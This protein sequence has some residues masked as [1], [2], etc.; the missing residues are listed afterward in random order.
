MRSYHFPPV[1]S[2]IKSLI[3]A[4][5]FIKNPFPILDEAVK[6]LGSTYTFY[7]GGMQKAILTIDPVASRHVLQKHHKAYEKSA[8]VTDIL[9]KY[10]G[11]G[12]LTSTGDHWLKQRRLIQPGFNRKRIESLQSLMRTEIDTCMKGWESFAETKKDLDAYEE[13]NQLTFRIVART[14]FSTSIEEHGLAELSRLISILQAYIIKDVRQPYKRWWFRISGITAKHIQLAKGVRELIRTIITERQKSNSDQDD[15]LTMLLEA[16][17]EESH[18]GMNE[19]QLIDECLILF[20]AGHETSAN[21]LSWM[22]YLL[23]MHQNEY[24]RLQNAQPEEQSLSIRNVISETLRLFPPAWVVDRISLEDDGI[25]GFNMPKGTVWIIYIRGMHRHPDYWKDP[26]RFLPDRWL[27][28]EL[29]KE[30][31]MPFGAGPRMC[32][33]EHFA[34]MEMQLIITA[35]INRWDIHLKNGDVG[36]K[37][38]ITLRPDNA[39][40]ISVTA[41]SSL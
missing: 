37:P 9:A 14:L 27:N 40:N 13:M 16:R 2:R 23:G 29:N 6:R 36:E 21:A 3:H 32:I 18:E 7:M 10:V 5:Q 20:V 31:Y 1:A 22:I 38:L 41:R 17:F 33:G 19:D 24:K 39:I 35:I 11:Q 26:D 4:N 12:L 28:V 8:I 30:A 15:L 25:L 34:M